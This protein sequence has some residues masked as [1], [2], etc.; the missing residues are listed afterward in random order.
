MQIITAGGR[1]YLKADNLGWEAMG[2]PDTQS[3]P[4]DK[5]VQSGSAEQMLTRSRRPHWPPS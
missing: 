3:L 2:N 1:A 5:W 4:V